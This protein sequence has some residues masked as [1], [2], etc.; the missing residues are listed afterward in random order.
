M[1]KKKKWTVGDERVSGNSELGNKFHPANLS[2]QVGARA[3]H[4]YKTRRVSK[5]NNGAG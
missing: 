5:G 1:K 3:G 2:M 4:R